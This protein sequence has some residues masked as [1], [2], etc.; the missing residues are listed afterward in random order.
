MTRRVPVLAAVAVLAGCALPP[1]G[2]PAGGPSGPPG[3]AT[4]AGASPEVAEM[5]RLV[6]R[7]R[8]SVGCPRLR[9]LRGAS[10][11]AQAHS[12]DMARRGYFSHVS[13]D[14]GTLAGRLARAGVA[15]R[16]AAEN[17]A[18]DP[19]SAARVLE[20]WILSPSH[21]ENLDECAYTHHGIGERDGRWTHVLVTPAP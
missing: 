17:I 3:V 21:R 11:A 13:P 16:M 4:P 15:L 12:D 2:D 1:P 9:W 19:R 10:A 20:G 5:E 18:R 7:H 8:A 6:N 14:G